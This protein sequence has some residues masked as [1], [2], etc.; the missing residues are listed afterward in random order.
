MSEDQAKGAAGPPGVELAPPASTLTDAAAGRLL[1]A[2][3]APGKTFD[4]I[5]RRPTWV[6]ALAFVT[7]LGLVA[8][9]I[10][11]QHTDI[12][13]SVRERVEKSASTLSPEQVDQQVAMAEKI[14]KIA[15]PL[16]ALVFVPLV[17]LGMALVFWLLL[18]LVGGEF[19][20]PV[21]LA[22]SVHAL[23]PQALSSLISLPLMANHGMYSPDE[24]RRGVLASNLAFLAP[25]GASPAV[26]ALLG[27]CDLFT[28]WS[29]ALLIVGYR[30]AGRTSAGATAGV[31]IGVWLLYVLG[32]IGMAAAFGR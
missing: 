29:L 6:L 30:R 4:S 9:V 32:K 24:L 23:L 26:V 15:A 1:G 27:S 11:V 8:N 5:V 2:L 10:G 18:R 13:A 31:V 3:V 7:V 28:F 14:S 22:V 21:S 12:A 16:A 20:Y 25:E 19:R 17:F